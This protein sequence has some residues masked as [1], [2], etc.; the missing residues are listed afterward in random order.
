[1]KVLIFGGRGMLGHKLVQTFSNVFDVDYTL[2][3][4]FKTV[5]RF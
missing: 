5:E 3:G 2:H 4:G 1:M